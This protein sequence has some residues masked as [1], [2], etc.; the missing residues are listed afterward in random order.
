MSYVGSS[1]PPPSPGGFECVPAVATLAKKLLTGM[2]AQ[3]FSSKLL[4]SRPRGCGLEPHRCPRARHTNP[5]LVLVQ[6]KKT[7]P[8]ITAS[9]AIVFVSMVK[10]NLKRYMQ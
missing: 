7:R 4:D 2:G 9:L 8:Y 3:W 6:P 5:S 1:P 10:S